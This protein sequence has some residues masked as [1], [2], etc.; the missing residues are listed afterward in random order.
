[1][2]SLTQAESTL[3]VYPERGGIVTSW[4][5]GGHEMFYLDQERFT[6]PTLSVRGG[7]PILFPICGNLPDNTYTHEGQTYS[8]K[9]HGFAREMPWNVVDQSEA[10]ITVQL[11]NTPTTEAVYPFGFQVDFT[12]ELTDTRLTIRQRYTNTGT[13][14]LPYSAGFH[15]YFAAPDKSALEFSLPSTVYQEK[16]TP[17]PRAFTG[18]DLTQPEIDWAFR[19]LTA[20]HATVVDRSR[21]LTLTLSFDPAF[22]TLVFW[23]VLGKDFYCLE[24]WTA[25]RNSLNS[26]EALRWLEPGATEELVCSFTVVLT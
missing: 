7:I 26:G 22:T 15:P 24:P 4:T 1:M 11:V 16:S 19:D 8:L 9:Q 14:P 13:T 23:T 2:L 17:E 5:V 18:F 12:Y 25:P 6:D 21:G 20:T 3:T 10:S